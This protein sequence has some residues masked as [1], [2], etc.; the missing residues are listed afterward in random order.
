MSISPKLVVTGAPF[1][2]GRQ[3]GTKVREMVRGGIGFYVR[4]WAQGTGK[5][6][7][8]VLELTAG[9][10]SEIA[11]FDS[12]NFEEIEGVAAG[13][14]VT[15]PEV[16]LINARYELTLATVFGDGNG[17]V[18]E[19]CTFLGAEPAATESGHTLIC[20]RALHLDSGSD[21]GQ[22]KRESVRCPQTFRPQRG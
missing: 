11:A 20:C 18:P 10:G 2:R 16:L 8:E 13:A 1:D 22:I 9:F 21:F 4:M 14:E 3:H 12:A 17:G 15:V 5:S 19:E 7:Q 6:R